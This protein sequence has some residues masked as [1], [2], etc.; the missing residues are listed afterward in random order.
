MGKWTE[1]ASSI[2]AQMD[3]ACGVMTD[4]QASTLVDM[5]PHFRADGSLVKV[6][7]R[8]GWGGKLYRAK[9]DLWATDANNPENAPD[10]W[11]EIL[12]RDGYRVLVAPITASNPVQPNEKCW[13]N[14]VLY[15]CIY[16]TV[17]VYRPSEY[18]PAWRVVE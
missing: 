17:C 10:L 12:Y 7:T 15:E 5:Y 18:A 6:T 13:E 9:V 11:E 14:D 16:H 2:I 3:R 4:A 1:L 8:V